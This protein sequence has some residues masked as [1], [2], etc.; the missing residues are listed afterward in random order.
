[1]ATAAFSIAPVLTPQTVGALADNLERQELLEKARFLRQL[2][3]FVE[4][5]VE[6]FF[7]PLVKPTKKGVFASRFTKLAR[8]FEPFRLYLN[9]Q[10]FS[11]LGGQD[12]LRLYEQTLLSALDPLMQTAVAMEMRP[13]LILATVRDYMKIMH[14]VVQ[15]AASAAM[16]TNNPTTVEQ[17][18]HT[19]NWLRAA[20][21]LDYGLT[22]VFL[23]LEM[24]IPRPSTADKD[25]LLSALRKS[26]FEFGRATTRVFVHEHLNHVLQ[27]LETP[28]LRI[29]RRAQARPPQLAHGAE[30]SPIASSRR[31]TEIGW[32]AKN[33][34][35]TDKYGGQWVVIEKDE[36]VAND[37]DYLK[38]RDVA[39][40]R[41]I[42]RPFIFFVPPKDSG[43]FMGV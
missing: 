4:G 12:F 5:T 29:G 21:R 3:P 22:S 39:K 35:L 31:Q 20:T 28:H 11:A 14:V 10:L 26:L 13:E 9:L 37:P 8:D 40:Q 25:A 27:G 15:L 1:M 32:I 17:L 43:G 36:L 23:V 19:V 41:G 42:R 16:Q 34:N 33:R 6:R 30:Q 7:V 2:R 38:A 18:G 24:A